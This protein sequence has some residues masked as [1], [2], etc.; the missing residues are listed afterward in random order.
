MATN[1]PKDRHKLLKMRNR[2]TLLYII[3]G[4][5]VMLVLAACNHE[6][7]YHHYE[8]TTVDGWSRTDTLSFSIPPVAASGNYEAQLELRTNESYPFVSLDVVAIQT[9]LPSGQMRCD[10]VKCQLADKNGRILGHGITQYQYSFPLGSLQLSEG[11]SLYVVMYHGMKR[12]VLP[13]ITDV[14]FQLKKPS[15]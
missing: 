6:A 9:I 7:V 8:H 5:I 4:C 14:G 2:Y 3:G 10:T 15:R 13:G 11:D 1:R 12:E